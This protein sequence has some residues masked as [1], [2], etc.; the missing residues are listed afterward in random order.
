MSLSPVCFL[1]G[2]EELRSVGS[3]P[4]VGH[5]QRAGLFVLELE[6]LVREFLAVDAPAARSVVVGEV[7]ALYH[8]T[9]NDSGK[10]R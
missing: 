8:E 10:T 3:R 7:S 9:G 1:D 6:I 4:G 2:Q 5:A